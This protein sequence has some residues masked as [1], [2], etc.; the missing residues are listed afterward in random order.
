M[1]VGATIRGNIRTQTSD[2][3]ASLTGLIYAPFTDHTK[4]IFD[5][6]WLGPRIQNWGDVINSESMG[7]AYLARVTLACESSGKHAAKRMRFKECTRVKVDGTIA[8][9]G[10]STKDE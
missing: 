1:C 10:S 3:L 4:A 5:T 2:M 9:A 7:R 8:F 6:S